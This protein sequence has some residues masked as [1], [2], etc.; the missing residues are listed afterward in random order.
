MVAGRGLNGSSRQPVRWPAALVG[1]IVRYRRLPAWAA[2]AL[3]L[4]VLWA[5]LWVIGLFEAGAEYVSADIDCVRSGARRRG[6]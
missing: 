4:A 5:G 2:F 6:L 3:S 1:L